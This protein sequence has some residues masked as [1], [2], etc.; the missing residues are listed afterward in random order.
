MNATNPRKWRPPADIMPLVAHNDL[1][2]FQRLRSEGQPVLEYG[3]AKKQDIREL[4]I[5]LLNMMPDTALAATERQFLTLIGQSNQIAQFY[6]HPFS[7]DELKR[8]ETAQKH[9]DQYYEPFDK[10]REDG[11]DGLI[12]TGANVTRPNLAEEPFWDPLIEIIDWAVENVTSILCSCLATHAVLQF[13]HDQQRIGLKDKRWGVYSHRIVER[14]HPVVQGINTK[15]DVPHSRFNEISREQFESV[16][17]HVLAESDEANVH[18]C[19]SED[20]FKFIF[21]QGHPEYDS[22]SLLKEYKREVMLY[23]NKL[24][25]DYPPFPEHYFRPLEKAIL[26]EYCDSLDDALNHGNPI[27]E[28]PE[29]LIT[30]SLHNT[31]HDTGVAVVGNWLGMIYQVTHKDRRIPYMDNIDPTDP[32][33]LK[34]R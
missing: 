19:I 17:C 11:L 26:D 7:I 2:T 15:F 27:P 12:I 29:H 13:R 24:R 16:G 32:L 6:I 25:H 31:W 33:G 3:R 23:A 34:T 14:A 5:G 1:P 28:F 22:I 10:L 21:F 18:M 20:M 30:Q 9:V 4:H 8:A